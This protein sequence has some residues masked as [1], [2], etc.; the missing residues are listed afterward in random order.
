MQVEE[1]LFVLTSGNKPD[2]SD[3][4][5]SINLPVRTDIGEYFELCVD[6]ISIWYSW[7]NI[8]AARGNNKFVYNNGVDADE[9]ITI[10]DG[11]YSIGGLNSYIQAR[12]KAN[13]DSNTGTTPESFYVIITPNINTNRVYMTVTGGF[14]VKFTDGTL[15]SLMGFNEDDE[16][17]TSGDAPN[18]ADFLNGL[19]SVLFR[20]DIVDGY[21][22]LLDGNSSNVL[23]S[24]FPA[25]PPS[26][27]IEIIPRNLLYLRVSQNFI[28]EIRMRVTDQAG[29]K[30]DLNGEPV[31]YFL[32]LRKMKRREDN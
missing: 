12:M 3:F 9:T 29:N 30:I 26:S 18:I 17:T 21:S 20:C 7:N 31:T 4:T 28:S 32:R 13:G 8:S 23:Y 19:S 24:F 11:N 1:T 25:S 5:T 2:S 16:I 10:P 22:S 15:Y 14:T 27:H 6:K